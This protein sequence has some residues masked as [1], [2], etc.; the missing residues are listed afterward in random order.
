ME[1]LY[2]LLKPQI[3]IP[4]HGDP[5]QIAEHKRLAQL[6]GAKVAITVEEGDVV[7]LNDGQP[8]ILGQVPV[9]CLAVDGKKI[10]PLKSEVIKKRRKMLEGGTVVAT[11]VVDKEGNFLTT[12]QISSFGLIEDTQE[13]QQKLIDFLQEKIKQIS[14]EN[15]KKDQMINETARSAIRQFISEFYGK[16][17]LIE[18]HLLRL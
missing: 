16:K 17:P 15:L 12:P 5:L 9:G 1:Y 6:W 7:E 8:N 18:I 11:L 14:P 13:D 4:V 3:A 2:G 10:I